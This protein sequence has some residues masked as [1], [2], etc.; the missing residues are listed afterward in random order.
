M[1]LT[2][3]VLRIQI[4]S[5]KNKKGVAWKCYTLLCDAVVIQPQDLQNF[6]S[7]RI[8]C[9]KNKKGVALK[10]YTL[11]CD[12][13]GIQPQDLQN[14]F[15]TRSFCSLNT[16]GEPTSDSPYYY[17]IPLGFKPKTFRTGI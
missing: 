2:V 5:F 8:F 1:W 13:V 12:P 4:F 15:S 17:V 14:F 7:T 3:F 11:L 6:F 10:C 9:F 16:K